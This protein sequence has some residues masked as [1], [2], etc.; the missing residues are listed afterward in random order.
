MRARRFLLKAV[1][2]GSC[3]ALNQAES[4]ACRSLRRRSSRLDALLQLR[5]VA[6]GVL[7]A[8]HDGARAT[9][10]R[11]GRLHRAAQGQVVGGVAAALGVG[12]LEGGALLSREVLGLARLELFD[13][14]DALAV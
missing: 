4:P 6:R 2:H 10:R 1:P 12:G 14:A 11:G 3:R 13:A 7:D 9:V 5:D 8:A